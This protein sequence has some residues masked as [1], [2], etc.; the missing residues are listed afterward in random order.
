MSCN[1]CS[2]T[3]QRGKNIINNNNK[4]MWQ[5]LTSTE[6]SERKKTKQFPR[7]FYLK[8]SFRSRIFIIF[9]VSSSSSFVVH[10]SSA[11]HHKCN[12]CSVDA[13]FRVYPCIVVY[14][15]VKAVSSSFPFH[16][17]FVFFL[18]IFLFPV[19]RATFITS[20]LMT[21][22][23]GFNR[24]RHLFLYLSGFAFNFNVVVSK[25]KYIPNAF[26]ARFP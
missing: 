13:K 24:F 10:I 5:K 21:L 2:S 7:T 17:C 11:A 20:W 16:W 1:T 3:I 15:L 6:E 4:K 8:F 12:I 19:N 22:T 18:Y 9:T 26:S 14:T 23:L 25:G